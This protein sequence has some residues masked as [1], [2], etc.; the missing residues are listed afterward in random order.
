MM[1]LD[2]SLIEDI[3]IDGIDHRDAPDYVDAYISS[4]YYD[5]REMT[6]DELDLLN[7]DSAFVYECV[8]EHMQ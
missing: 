7:E 1:K 8:I 2:Y 6:Q 3:Q 4:A 5:G